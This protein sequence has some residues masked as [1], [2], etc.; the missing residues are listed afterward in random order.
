M[1]V[2]IA[3]SETVDCCFRVFRELGPGLLESVYEVVLCRM[4]EQRGVPVERQAPVS[5]T[6][7]GLTFS[8]LLKIDI[9][10]ADCLI[11]ELKSV[12]ATLP[13]HGKQVLTYLRLTG[14]SLGLL[15]NFGVPRFQG[16]VRRIVNN[17]PVPASG[18]LRIHKSLQN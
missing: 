16:C 6:Y 5:F 17:H 10:V 3:A 14:I 4:L 15:V 1:D 9:L 2:E 11:V 12:E 8:N 18:R 7:A 13:V